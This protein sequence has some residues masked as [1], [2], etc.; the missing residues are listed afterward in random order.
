MPALTVSTYSLRGRKNMKE[1][2]DLAEKLQ[3]SGIE[4]GSDVHWPD[5][6]SSEDSSVVKDAV[7][8]NHW[9]SNLDYTMKTATLDNFD[10]A[11]I[12]RGISELKDCLTL[13][14]TLGVQAVSVRV[15][16]IAQNMPDNAEDFR[17]RAH[18]SIVDSLKEC[19]PLAEASGTYLLIENAQLRPTEVLETYDQYNELIDG[20][21][22]DRVKFI[23]DPAH[24]HT[25]SGIADGINGIGHNVHSVHI[26]DNHGERGKDEHLELGKGNINLEPHTE[27]LRSVPGTVSFKGWD[28]TEEEESTVRS[29]TLIKG[30]LGI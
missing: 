3:V 7:A 2:I 29:L 11:R 20:I 1:F 21:A 26:H 18:A 24:C 12:Q 15:G 19:M 9:S 6:L 4:L 17:K 27:F 5:V 25:F 30:L 13:A 16:L 10:P 23:L 28:E 14:G 8:R 22:S